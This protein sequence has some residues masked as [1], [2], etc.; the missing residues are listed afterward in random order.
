MN[1]RSKAFIAASAICGLISAN[2]VAMAHGT[3]DMKG[4]AM[5]PTVTAALMIVGGEKATCRI[6]NINDQF[7]VMVGNGNQATSRFITGVGLPCY[8]LPIL[9]PAGTQIS[10]NG[11]L[12]D[13]AAVPNNALESNVGPTVVEDCYNVEISTVGLTADGGSEFDPTTSAINA[14]GYGFAWYD[15]DTDLK[16]GPYTYTVTG[17]D[18]QSCPLATTAYNTDG[19]P[20]GACTILAP[21]PNVAQRQAR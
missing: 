17:C 6:G 14:Q 20:Y 13:T 18:G 19:G 9:A 15:S 16:P 11:V 5:R 21:Y 3:P 10:L 1:F 12:Q 4:A 2:S 7:V 8:V